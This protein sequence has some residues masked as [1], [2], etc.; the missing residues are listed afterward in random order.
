MKKDYLDSLVTI[1]IDTREMEPPEPLVRVMEAVEQFK[2]TEKIVM[3]HRH[4]PCQLLDKL[5]ALGLNYNIIENND[6]SVE[7]TIWRDSNADG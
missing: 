2:E 1:L 7:L 6:G 3:L 4:K 5:N